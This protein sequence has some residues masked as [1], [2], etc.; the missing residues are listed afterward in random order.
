MPASSHSTRSTAPSRPRQASRRPITAAQGWSEW[1]RNPLSALA[2]FNFDQPDRGF[3]QPNFKD[4]ERRAPSP[5]TVSAPLQPESSATTENHECYPNS[6][7]DSARRSVKSGRSSGSSTLG[8]ISSRPVLWP[9][10]F[11]H[12]GM[13]DWGRGRSRP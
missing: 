4:G 8:G 10:Y 1:F 3:D 9:S 11:E 12:S 6:P 5:V 2:F 7:S 13:S